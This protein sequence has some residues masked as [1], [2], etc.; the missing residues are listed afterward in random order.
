M[1]IHSAI[2]ISLAAIAMA[3]CATKANNN[4]DA[5]AKTLPVTELKAKDTTMHRSYVTGIEAQQNVEIRARVNGFLDAIHVD[6][7]DEVKKGQIL[8][9]ISDEEF[10][11]EVAKARAILSSVIAEA[12]GAALEVDRVKLLVEKKVVAASELEVAKARLAAAEAKTDEARSSLHA[13][14]NRLQYTTIRAPFNGVIDRI[15]LKKGSLI[16]EGA[17]F[18]TISDVANVYAYFNVSETEYLSYKNAIDNHK[19]EYENVRLVLADGTD[20][21]FPGKIETIEGEFEENTGS[22]A[23]RAKF[24]NPKK[25]LKHGASGKVMLTSEVEDAVL[26]PGKAVFEMQ[27]KNY[28]FVVGKDNK[29]KMKNFVPLSR[30]A[31][32]YIVQ[33]GLAPGEKVVSE[34]VQS[35]RDGMLIQPRMVPID[36]LLR[37]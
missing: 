21:D 25:L 15:P 4:A 8:F 1:Q 2:Y 26:V 3:G 18:T 13:A 36:S 24:P 34:G 22:I 14:E 16:T 29:V 19:H 37:M 33:D 31:Q 20:Y 12:K 17:L 30:M 11:A 9:S 27:D 7:G 5:T 32:C 35:I 10:K 6:E 23:F 28:V